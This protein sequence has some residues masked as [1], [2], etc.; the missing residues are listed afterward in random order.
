MDVEGK[1]VIIAM[2]PVHMMMVKK[3]KHT[4]CILALGVKTSM[5]RCGAH[6]QKVGFFLCL[7]CDRC[8]QRKDKIMLTGWSLFDENGDLMH[9]V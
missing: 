4:K 5:E 9:N 3:V 2:L 6:Y 1:T 7:N 8:I